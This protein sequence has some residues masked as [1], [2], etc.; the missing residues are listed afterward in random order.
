MLR[1]CLAAALVAAAVFAPETIASAQ[2]GI[3]EQR[4]SFPPGKTGTTVRDAVSG[5]ESISFLVD[6]EAGQTMDVRLT[7]SSNAIYF[8][9]YEPGRAPGDQA[10]ATGDITG[11]M[12]PDLNVFRGVLPSSDTYTISTYLVRSAARRGERAEFSLDV[13]ISALTDSAAPVEGDFA[14]GMGGG[15]DFLEVRT[16]GSGLRLRSSPSGASG[17]VATL[18][19]GRVVRNLGCRANE[20]RRWCRVATLADPGSEGW[21]AGEFLVESD[22]QPG[23]KPVQ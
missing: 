17:V 22:Y 1:A 21:A 4:L 7:S 14:N 20:G 10:L 23:L 9:V 13:S 18:E 6:A 8:N 2:D 3:R 12:V 19:P 15:P 5:R 11:P 16:S